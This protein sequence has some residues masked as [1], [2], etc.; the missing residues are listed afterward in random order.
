MTA[1]NTHSSSNTADAQ[2]LAPQTHHP[3]VKEEIAGKKIVGG[4]FEFDGRFYDRAQLI[5]ALRCAEWVFIAYARASESLGLGAQSIQWADLNLAYDHGVDA[6]SDAHRERINAE[7]VAQFHGVQVTGKG[8]VVQTLADA[9]D[10]QVIGC[11]IDEDHLRMLLT[12]SRTLDVKNQDGA[13]LVLSFDMDQ[14]TLVA[15]IISSE[16]GAA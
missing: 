14:E 6:L 15:E 10:L 1:S 9:G 16:G 7:C 3:A 4:G 12:T 5:A 11:N 8:I 13:D 2:F